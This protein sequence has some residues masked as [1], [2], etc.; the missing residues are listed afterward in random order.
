MS[1]NRVPL[2][3]EHATAIKTINKPLNILD[4]LNKG[5]YELPE[6]ATR[7]LAGL[8]EQEY[9][10]LTIVSHDIYGPVDLK[11]R[12]IYP[13]QI[14][15][16][17]T[18]PAKEM[19]QFTEETLCNSHRDSDDACAECCV[20]SCVCAIGAASAPFTIVVGAVSYPA[21]YLASC[22]AFFSCGARDLVDSLGKRNQKTRII[23]HNEA[24][25]FNEM[26]EDEMKQTNEKLHAPLKQQMI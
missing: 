11:R 21:S 13:A 26:L 22:I 15:E 25:T 19:Y 7:I 6:V 16:T 4:M 18:R 1:S 24:Q 10:K 8:N 23:Y 12:L 9:K 17:L 5:S 3:S 20:K 2:L 14:H